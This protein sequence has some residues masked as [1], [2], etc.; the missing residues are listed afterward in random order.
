MRTRRR[1]ARHP[2]AARRAR[3]A[4][5]IRRARGSSRTTRSARP[6]RSRSRRIEAPLALFVWSKQPRR[7]GAHHRLQ[8]HRG[9]VR[10]APQPDP[11]QGQPRRC[12]CSRS[13]TSASTTRAAALFMTYQQTKERLAAGAPTGWRRSPALGLTGIREIAVTDR[14]TTFPPTSRYHGI[15]V[16]TL[17]RARRPR[18]RLP[19]PPL[20][21]AAG[22]L[23]ALCASTSSREGER[24]D[25][26]PRSTSATPSS[27]GASATRT[28][29]SRR[30][31]LTDE[32]GRRAPDHAA[33]DVPRGRG[34]VTAMADR[35]SSSRC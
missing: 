32:A 22:A 19:A 34:A 6:G 1:R 9:G 21:A 8:H 15:E 35:A 23:R 7:P 31:T 11:R 14:A 26:S 13:T 29:R 3:D 2:A 18:R 30:E 5:S 20:R 25:T 24:L 4:R 27:S 17:E 33:G 12:A 28:A 10:P 16:A